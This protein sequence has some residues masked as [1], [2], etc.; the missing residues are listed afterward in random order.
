MALYDFAT[1]MSS[2][3]HIVICRSGMH[4]VPQSSLAKNSLSPSLTSVSP[5][6]VAQWLSEKGHLVDPKVVFRFLLFSDIVSLDHLCSHLN[7]HLVAQILQVLLFP[8][9]FVQCLRHITSQAQFRS[10]VWYH[11]HC[12]ECC[13]TCSLAGHG[14]FSFGSSIAY[15]S[16]NMV[17]MSFPLDHLYHLVL[18]D[19]SNLTLWVAFLLFRNL[20]YCSCVFVSNIQ[21]WSKTVHKFGC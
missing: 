6:V 7:F 3:R 21:C 12:I 4:L 1:G 8:Q 20:I 9:H 19:N 14:V 10:V 18:W 5:C 13:F 16:F 11:H 17:L 2:F 15:C